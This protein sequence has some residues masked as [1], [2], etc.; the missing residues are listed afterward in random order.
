MTHRFLSGIY[1]HFCH[2]RR[3]GI[4]SG[5]KER[6]PHRDKHEARQL[7]LGLQN[8]RRSH[9]SLF[10][11]LP[12][13]PLPVG[14]AS[15]ERRFP[16]RAGAGHVW[17]TPPAWRSIK[18]Q[19]HKGEDRQWGAQLAEVSTRRG[20][21]GFDGDSAFR[22][23][24]RPDTARRQWR[25][26]REDVSEQIKAEDENVSHTSVVSRRGSNATRR[27][28]GGK[29]DCSGC[30]EDVNVSSV[31]VHVHVTSACCGDGAFMFSRFSI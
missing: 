6:K 21:R 31:S 15:A 2:I 5:V 16:R 3:D 13:P 18:T 20:A 19:R 22:R 10:E 12:L 25:P 23:G 26:S 1:L 11:M 30:S 29:L 27:D 17:A 9:L 28:R 8:S 24:C 7:Q 4:R 14:T